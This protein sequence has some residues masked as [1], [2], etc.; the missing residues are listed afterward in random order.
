MFSE[1]Q[2]QVCD[3]I[4]KM[5]LN[6]PNLA[7]LHYMT[8]QTSRLGYKGPYTVVTKYLVTRIIDT[9]SMWSIMIHVRESQ[10]KRG[11]S[12]M[13]KLINVGT[14]DRV[15]RI[16]LGVVLLVAGFLTHYVLSV[17]LLVVGVVSLITG[18]FGFCA[19]YRLFGINTC[20]VK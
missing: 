14:S 1:N 5:A 7:Q 6:K 8:M 16:L 20:R 9:C 15:I 18:L 13:S 19:I 2:E 17:I 11:D 3:A 12:Q 4:H 10:E